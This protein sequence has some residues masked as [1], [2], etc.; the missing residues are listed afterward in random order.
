MKSSLGAVDE[1]GNFFRAQDA[2]QV[3]RLLRIRCIGH[4]PGFLDRLRVEEPQSGQPLCHGGRGQLSLTEQIRLVLADV[5][6]SKLIRR[7]PEITR[8]IRDRLD[9][10]VYGSLSVITTLEFFEHHFAKVGHRLAPYDPTL[11]LHKHCRHLARE[12]VCR[13]AASFKRASRRSESSFPQSD[14]WGVRGSHRNRGVSQA[15]FTYRPSPSTTTGMGRAS[16][17]MF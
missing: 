16:V 3:S 10:A 2:G 11:F 1:V 7:A 13:E 14:L 8:E 9:V 17:G 4:A 12:S 6:R 15:G 5:L